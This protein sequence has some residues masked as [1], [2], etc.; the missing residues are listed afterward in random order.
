MVQAKCGLDHTETA[1]EGAFC[2]YAIL[3]DAVFVVEDALEDARFRMHPWWS[4]IPACA[5]TP[6]P[7]CMPRTDCASGFLSVVDTVPRRFSGEDR[8][9]LTDLASVVSAQLTCTARRPSCRERE[10]HYR[11]LAETPPTWWSG[12][13]STPCAVTFSRRCAPCSA[14]NPEHLVGTKPLDQVHPE[15]REPFGRILS[16][17]CE[18]RLDR[19]VA[20]Q[21]YRARTEAGSGWG[22]DLQRHPRRRW[23][24]HRVRGGGARH[25]RAQGSRAP[26]RPHGAHDALTDLAQ[27]HAL[28]ERLTQEVAQSGRRLGGFAVL[29]LDLDRFKSVN[30]TLGHQAGDSLLRI[31]AQRCGASRGPRIPWR[32]SAATSS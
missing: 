5:S 15:D 10:A 6:V 28:R 30:D 8:A 13:P 1:R 22:G 12:R 24:S 27:P 17:M 20:R 19:T 18:G 11:L 3:S 4:R 31:V 21:R 16:E 29:C 26:H 23:A 7:R 25:H 2:N 32:A 9:R 14:T